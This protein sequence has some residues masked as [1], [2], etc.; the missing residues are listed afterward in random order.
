MQN[1]RQICQKNESTCPGPPEFQISSGLVEKQRSYKQKREI[2]IKYL[3]K[4]L[5]IYFH[6]KQ[7]NRILRYVAAR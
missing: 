6:L 7:Q 1:P 5:N 3:I 2:L 4:Y